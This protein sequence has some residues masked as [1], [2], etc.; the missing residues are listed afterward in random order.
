MGLLARAFGVVTAPRR[1]YAAIAAH[2]RVVGALV[3]SLAIM[4]TGTLV[5]LSTEVGQQA[6]I[7]QQVQQAE[8]FGRP[9]NDAQYQQMERFAPYL[10]YIGAA[11][12]VVAVVLGSLVMAGLSWLVFN[13][14]LGGD[15]KF[16]QVY[17]IVAHSGFVL[18]LAPI[19]V[20]PL[21]YVRESLTSPTAVAVFLPFLEE[22]TFMSR[23]LGTIDL[24]YIWWLV[25]LAIGLA[26]L[27]RRRTG[28]IAVTL[29][30]IYVVL[31]SIGAGVRTAL[32]G[33]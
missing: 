29:L 8:A 32:A 2:A 12:Q 27:Y 28:S 22:N 4:V 1:T 9:M 14:L 6:V 26:V 3:L 23:L 17:A 13:A 25:N 5:F 10:G 16:K 18:A 33:A 15:A 21:D 20:L 30:I 11:F 24:F 31:A 7:D 19:F